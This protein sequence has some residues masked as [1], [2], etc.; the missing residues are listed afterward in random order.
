MLNVCHIHGLFVYFLYTLHIFQFAVNK[1]IAKTKYET[2][3]RIENWI[4]ALCEFVNTHVMKKNS[5]HLNVRVKNYVINSG[6]HTTSRLIS[7][8]FPEINE[9]PMHLLSAAQYEMSN[10]IQFLFETLYY[11]IAMHKCDSA[12]C[13]LQML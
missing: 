10:W 13:H 2:C 9:I 4:K 11:S 5:S 3:T 6:I 7:I 1:K 8:L 12:R